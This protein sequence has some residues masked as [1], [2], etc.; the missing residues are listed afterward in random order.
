LKAYR[1]ALESVLRA[2]RA[3]ENLARQRLAQAN[4]RFRD[5][6]A[7][8]QAAGDAYRCAAREPAPSD[9]DAFVAARAHE[10]RMAEAVERAFR[11]AK[12]RE[13]ETATCYTAWVEAGKLVAS[14]ERLDRRRREEWALEML[15]DEAAAIDDVVTSRW[16]LA[17]PGDTR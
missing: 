16:A 4:G 3:Q 5:A 12:E 8:H 15:R 11:T 1:F 2:R 14:L 7:L 13:V 17:G 6:R 10:M 9:R